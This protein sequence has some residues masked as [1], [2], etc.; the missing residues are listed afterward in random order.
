MKDIHLLK[1]CVSQVEADR[2]DLRWAVNTIKAA[3]FHFELE[4]G[5]SLI[6][7]FHL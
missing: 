5:R 6:E 4:P 2:P 7:C 1:G 3:S